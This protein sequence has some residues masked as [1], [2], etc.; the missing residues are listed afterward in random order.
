MYNK[1]VESKVLSNK[2]SFSHKGLIMQGVIVGLT[3]VKGGKGGIASVKTLQT[4]HVQM[5]NRPHNKTGVVV[6]RLNGT[7]AKWN[8]TVNIKNF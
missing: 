4:G 8:P 7:F 3:T 1:E 5:C 6:R 2:T